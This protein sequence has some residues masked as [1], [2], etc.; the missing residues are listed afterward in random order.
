MKLA[1]AISL[2]FLLALLLQGCN[3]CFQRSVVVKPQPVTDSIT[4]DLP[5]SIFNIPVRYDL[6]NFEI[7]INQVIKGK[8][9][10][11]VINPLN[12]KRDEA[13]LILTKTGTIRVS[14]N[15]KKLICLVPLQ[16]EAVLLK[17]RMGKGLTNSAD[18]VLTTVNIELST[19][20]SLDKNWN[21]VTAFEIEKLQ[22]IKEPV[23]QIGPFKKN[24]KK[25]I[26]EWLEENEDMLTKIM[27]R[28]INKTVSMEPPL[29]KVWKDL[30]KP[31]IIH[32][33]QPNVWLTFNCESIEGKI[34]LGP[35]T[36]T[37]ETRVRATTKIITDTTAMPAAS[38]LPAY[39]LL[40]DASTESDIH[41]YAFTSFAEI[42]E[43]LNSQLKEKI[44]NAE[45]Y[46]LSV[47]G[48]NAYASE[49]GLSIEIQTSRDVKGK[50]I[51]SGK[52]EFDPETQSLMIRNFDYSVSSN[53]TLVNA[54]DML[55]HQQVKDTI[56]S[57]LII[58]MRA[59]IDTVPQLVETAIAKGKSSD[60]IDLEFEH[61]AVH[62]CEISMG[63]EGIHFII[64]AE[65]TAG[66][67]LKKLKPGKRLRIKKAQKE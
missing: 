54:G 37:C 3:G 56:A 46:S 5:L 6:Q 17:S 59:L 7:W 48:I 24:L 40:K 51:A 42:N 53:N 21:L 34:V 10:E 8:F 28:E 61:L 38:P 9:L 50:L 29:E 62:R 16:L 39:H 45:G 57:R 66:I 44:F 23:F 55:L 58:G 22:W 1:P 32:K 4:V 19:P 67:L 43:E 2:V 11:T 60:K 30:Q 52:L 47:K 35:S 25:K 49:A 27:D 63:A 15:G 64:H 12:D 14:S 36:I 31:I 18:T 20:V 41:L 65:A 13:R 26:N 33:K